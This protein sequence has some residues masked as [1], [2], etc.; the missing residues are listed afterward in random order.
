[1][2]NTGNDRLTYL[3][4]NSDNNDPLRIIIC[5]SLLTERYFNNS[6]IESNL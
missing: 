4:M 6:G 3:L 5:I 2:K 1:M